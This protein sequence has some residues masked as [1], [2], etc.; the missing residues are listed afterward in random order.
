MPNGQEIDAI[1][2]DDLRRLNRSVTC[3]RKHTGE[4][5]R[6]LNWHSQFDGHQR[7]SRLHVLNPSRGQGR[8]R[9]I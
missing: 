8:P 1:I 6:S 5:R 4:S 9:T 7:V 3:R 2:S